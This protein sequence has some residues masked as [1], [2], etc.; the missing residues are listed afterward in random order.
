M[1]SIKNILRYTMLAGLAGI[2]LNI[3][4]LGLAENLSYLWLNWNL[5]L[6]IVPLFFAWVFIVAK[7]KWLQIISFI[8]WLGFLPN[9]PYIVT[10]FIHMADVGP[11]SILWYDGMM[12]FL[13]T[14]AG[15]II[16]VGSTIIIQRYKKW[17][18]WFI[19]VIGLLSGFGVYLGRYIRF[20]T[21]DIITDLLSIMVTIGDIVTDPNNHQPVILMTLVITFIF[22][23]FSKF[24]T[25]HEK[26][27]N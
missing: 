25:I 10:D 20:N 8:L 1:L 7:Q 11:Q 12:I 3:G 17:G 27:K 18:E 26:T 13:Y 14:L 2:V 22:I 9:S 4:R 23:I 24:L 21:W 15:M 16:W 19:P 5:F 6:A